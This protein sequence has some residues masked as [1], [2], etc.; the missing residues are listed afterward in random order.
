MH[1][2]R[3]NVSF[4]SGKPDAKLDGAPQTLGNDAVSF[5]TLEE[6][7]RGGKILCVRLDLDID[8]DERERDPLLSLVDGPFGS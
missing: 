7:G 2:P 6:L 4:G 1:F 3:S 5:G 8:H